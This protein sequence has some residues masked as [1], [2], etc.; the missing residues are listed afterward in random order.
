MVAGPA[1]RDLNKLNAFVRVAEYRSFTKASRDLHTSPSVVSRHIS[2]LESSLGFSLMTRSTHGVQLTDAGEGLLRTCLQMLSGVDE[3][4]VETRNAQ[5]GPYGSLRV[6]APAD[7]ASEIVAP[8][9][10]DF[11]RKHPK[12]RIDISVSQESSGSPA[13]GFDIIIA[14]RRPDGPGLKEVE[15]GHINYVVCA[16]PAYFKDHGVPTRVAQLKD[17]NCLVHTSFSSKE[18]LFQDGGKEV[19]VHVRGSLSSD[20]SFVLAQLAS[21]GVG[22]IRVPRYSVK[23]ELAK[24]ALRSILENESRSRDVLRAYYS[25]TKHLPLKVSAFLEFVQKAGRD[26]W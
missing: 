4:L 26:M 7:F 11:S 2:E 13:D 18:W 14:N 21:R 10:S 3:Y 16:S 8:L 1:L 22:I 17:H 20:N 5:T 15:L 9:A 12:V 19:S 25:K 6:M 23:S 24:G